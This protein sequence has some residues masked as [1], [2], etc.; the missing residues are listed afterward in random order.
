MRKRV[1]TMIAGVLWLAA[2]ST[3]AHA[4]GFAGV[5]NFWWNLIGLAGLLGIRGIWR[6]SDNDGYTDDPV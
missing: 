1:A 3:P 2:A 5:D 4:A 6:E